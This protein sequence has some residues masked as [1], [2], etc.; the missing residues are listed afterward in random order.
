MTVWPAMTLN[1]ATV[2]EAKSPEFQAE[3][4]RSGRP[5]VVEFGRSGCD[6]TLDEFL[7]LIG[8][9]ERAVRVYGEER[10]GT[11][12]D[13][14]EGYCDFVRLNP[15]DYASWIRDGTARKRHA[16]MA[17]VDLTGTAL[18]AQV[19]AWTGG[20]LDKLFPSAMSGFNFWLG[21]GGHVE[22]LHYDPADGV[23]LQLSGT[24]RVRLVPPQF[25]RALYPFP[26][27]SR[28]RPW[29]SRV[30]LSE[31]DFESFPRAREALAA[32][33]ETELKAGQGLFI[34]AGWWHE[35]SSLGEDWTCSVNRFFAVRPLRRLLGV[36][37]GVPLYA[38]MANR[39]IVVAVEDVFR[40][41]DAA[42][43]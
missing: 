11:R 21:P 33:T 15:A 36:Y 38:A 42:G 32:M 23:L 35:V 20:F 6:R 2:E 18:E 17:Q 25:S 30:E 37:R 40:K 41:R 16:Y 8:P 27:W 34:P 26:V 29:F 12:R 31:P 10:I 9:E 28:I 24:K 39:K 43:A 5:A 4:V 3:Y 19:A 13:Q 22:P 7:S 14:W 1:V